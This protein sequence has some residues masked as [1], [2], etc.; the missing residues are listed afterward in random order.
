LWSIATG[1]LSDFQQL[2]DT[3]DHGIRDISSL[4]GGYAFGTHDFVLV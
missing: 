1:Q 3:I 4:S 2:I